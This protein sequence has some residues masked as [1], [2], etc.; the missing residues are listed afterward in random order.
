MVLEEKVIEEK[1]REW[2][3]LRELS[4]FVRKIYKT[5]ELD[6][7]DKPENFDDLLYEGLRL[8]GQIKEEL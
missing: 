6:H 5:N 2:N 3:L 7:L 8:T 1:S 4:A